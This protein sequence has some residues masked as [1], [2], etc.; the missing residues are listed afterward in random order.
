MPRRPGPPPGAGHG[1][2]ARRTTAKLADETACV[3][4]T[5][6]ERV[7]PSAGGMTEGRAAWLGGDEPGPGPAAGGMPLAEHG[8]AG[9]VSD[10]AEG[11][12]TSSHGH[13]NGSASFTFVAT[14]AGRATPGVSG[15]TRRET[16]VATLRAPAP[17][18]RL[19]EK[20]HR[21]ASA[22]DSDGPR[23]S[24]GRPAAFFDLDKTIIAKSST[25]AFS[26]SF[27]AGGLISR[28]V[29]AAQRLRAVRLPG[30]RCRPRPDGED[31]GVPLRPVR[32]LG[33]ADRARHRRRHP[34]Q[35][36]RPAGLRRGGLADRGAPPRGTRRGHR[37]RLRRRGGR[38]DRRDARR[39]RA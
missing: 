19:T 14:Y 32:R 24:T 20:G 35:H 4:G 25:L 12:G 17:G 22:T 11:R 7:R 8:L 1:L 15:G 33:R 34:A 28:A 31:A 21:M 9:P 37:L 29:G 16:P 39:G 2:C 36:R 10:V 26:R 3:D 5:A 6:G 27:Y 23:S 38:A 18:L 13:G 30:G